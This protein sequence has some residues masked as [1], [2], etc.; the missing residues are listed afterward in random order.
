[1]KNAMRWIKNFLQ[2]SLI[3]LILFLTIDFTI[4]TLSGYRGFSKFFISNSVEG[5]MNKPHFSGLFGSPLTEFRGSV[6]I[7]KNGERASSTHGCKNASSKILFLGDSITA[8]FEVDDEETFVSLFNKKCK[9]KDKIGINFGVR[10]H[11]T[12]AVIGTYL[13]VKN[14]L[15]HNKV[16]YL[17]T[18]TDFEA[19]ID[20]KA[21][22]MVTKKFGR[23]FNNTIIKPDKS[24]WFRLYMGFRIFVGDNFSLTTFVLTK[25]KKLIPIFFARTSINNSNEQIDFTSQIEAAYKLISELNYLV[26]ANGSKLYVVPQPQ[27]YSKKSMEN[28]LIDK[29]NNKLQADLPDV[30]YIVNIDEK[31]KELV[32]EDKK[33]IED[34]RFKTDLHLSEYGHSI[35]AQIL[36]TI[37][38]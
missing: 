6:N 28:D 1:M 27:L 22:H 25:I 23:R 35:M 11:D 29:L 13:R 33:K 7:G 19:N 31:V 36:D 32:A 21:Y 10:A 14:Y 4:T 5:R 26:A 16:V 8:G 9:V 2:I 30:V 37:T 15:P 17:M 38:D 20:P 3:T 18:K 34:M 24:Q 12:H